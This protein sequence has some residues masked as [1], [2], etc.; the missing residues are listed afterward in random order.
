MPVTAGGRTRHTVFIG[1][2]FVAKYPEGGGVFWVP[3]QYLLG[4]GALGVE[5]HWLEYVWGGDDP[6]TA[7]RFINVFRRRVGDFGVADR[8]TVCFFPDDGREDPPGRVQYLGA[9]DAPGLAARARDG[10][11]LNLANSVTRPL[12]AAFA[13]TALFDIDPGPFQLWARESDLSVGSHDVHLTA[14]R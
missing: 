2:A 3:L 11:L 13:R 12:R 4:F 1:S 9:L 14:G 8:V 6:E 7:R 5:A 10:L